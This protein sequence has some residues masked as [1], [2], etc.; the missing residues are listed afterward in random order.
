VVVADRN[1]RRPNMRGASVTSRFPLEAWPRDRA[2][3]GCTAS[4]RPASARSSDLRA[5]V[6]RFGM[7]SQR[8]SELV[9]IPIPT[10]IEQPQRSTPIRRTVKMKRQRSRWYYVLPVAV[11]VCLAISYKLPPAGVAL[12]FI[13]SVD[14]SPGRERQQAHPRSPTISSP[15]FSPKAITGRPADSQWQRPEIVVRAAASRFGNE[16]RRLNSVLAGPLATCQA[17]WPSLKQQKLLPC[18]VKEPEAPGEA[19]VFKVLARTAE[20]DASSAA[21]LIRCLD[22]MAHGLFPQPTYEAHASA[23][24]LF[25][26][27]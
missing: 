11:P 16:A 15:S 22:R 8:P 20:G 25:E 27:P 23:T 18:V 12:S 19:T 26:R 21:N 1:G 17:R 4:P 14:P 2:C 13:G 6:Q 3:R 7:R 9:F 10:P 24:C 5:N